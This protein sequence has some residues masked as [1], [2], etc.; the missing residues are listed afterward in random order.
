MSATMINMR[1]GCTASASVPPLPPADC[2]ELGGC[3][4]LIFFLLI[5]L[6]HF[7]WTAAVGQQ[8]QRFCLRLLGEKET[9]RET[10]RNASNNCLQS[11][12]I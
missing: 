3:Q 8:E 11:K 2:S 6:P 12:L 9:E 7:A 1:D 5:S 4:K 10:S